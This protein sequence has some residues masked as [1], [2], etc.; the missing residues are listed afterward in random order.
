MAGRIRE[1]I[2]LLASDSLEGRRTGSVGE[3][4]AGDFIIAHYTAAGIG[5][6]K[7]EYR[8][9]FSFVWGKEIG[10]GTRVKING[11]NMDLKTEAFPLSFSAA[12]KASGDV[13]PD[14]MEDGSIWMVNLYADQDEANNAHFDAEKSMFDRSRDAQKHG[15]TAIIFY[16]AFGSKW[17]PSFN[18][19]SVNESVD[20]PVIFL[21][22]DA[23]RKYM[24]VADTNEEDTSRV[25]TLVTADLYI[26]IKKTDRT[27][28][29]VAAYIDNHAPYT[30]ILGAHYDHL[31][32][33]ED[34]SSMEANSLGQIHNGADDNASGTAALMEL[35][36]WVK[37]K[38]PH[39]YN[40]LFIHFSGEELGLLGSKAIVKDEHIDS[41]NA[42]YML[43][44]DMVGRLNDSTH[45]LDMGGIGTSPAWSE[46]LSKP[47]KEFKLVI[48]S[49]GVGPSDHS[50]FYHEGIPVLFFFT[51]QHKDYHKPSDD[52]DKINYKGEV[53]V[54]KYA[55]TIIL[56]MDKDPK[57]RFTPTKQN[58]VGKVNFKVTLGIMPDYSYQDG[59]VRVDGVSE[60]KPAKNAG[61]K[62]GDIIIKLGDIKV[63]GM[64]SYMEAL[65]KFKAGDKTNVT[66]KRAGIEMVLPLE[67]LK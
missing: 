19:L 34:G 13:L 9:P 7:S 30:V 25:K 56:K 41:T 37:K 46:L 28:T 50:S 39:H 60:K 4:K 16:D 55:E 1:R 27:G 31:G 18:G 49:S 64:Q 10:E 3:H 35:A 21:T 14:V 32:R 65:S 43:N 58:S 23:Y 45:S 62:E 61:I 63:Q 17:P 20:I 44:M 66:V 52:A 26:N 11:K 53:E 38:K 59:G 12:K 51:G 67:F 2:Y 22:H 57:P 54:I 33:G 40:Y 24:P 42:S 15:A 36:S 48:D 5:P 47:N 6:Y 8:H 29:N